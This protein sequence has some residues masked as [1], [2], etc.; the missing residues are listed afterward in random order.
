[1]AD[2]AQDVGRDL[3]EGHLIGLVL[4]EAPGSGKHGLD[5]AR[6]QSMLSLDNELMTITGDQ[7]HVHGVRTLAVSVGIVSGGGVHGT[8]GV[9]CES[10][11]LIE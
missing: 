9:A 5:C 2:L 7:Q 6:V 3:A 8:A 4:S 1:M 11:S 10:H